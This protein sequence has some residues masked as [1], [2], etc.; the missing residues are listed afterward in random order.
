[1]LRNLFLS[2][3]LLL[4]FLPALKGDVLDD[5]EV[6]LAKVAQVGNYR[7]AVN[8][9]ESRFA[10]EYERSLKHLINL[11]RDLDR[12]SGRAIPGSDFAFQNIARELA[13]IYEFNAEKMRHPE[14]YRKKQKN[15][16]RNSKKK[17]LKNILQD[18]APLFK[19]LLADI[20]NLRKSGFSQEGLPAS[21]SKSVLAGDLLNFRR[22]LT[23]F[24]TFRGQY[25][26]KKTP[27]A[28]R[29]EFDRRL[30]TLSNS[31]RKLQDA[32]Q[33]YG[34]ESASLECNIARETS[35]ILRSFE[36]YRELALKGRRGSGKNTLSTYNREIRYSIRKIEDALSALS[37]SGLETSFS[38]SPAA[39]RKMPGNR[40]HNLSREA[41][42][43]ELLK[44]RLRI[45]RGNVSLDGVDR[46]TLRKYLLTLTKEERA[47]Y[48]KIRKERSAGGYS[49]EAAARAAL[50]NIQSRV[51]IS[52]DKK[53]L[54]SLLNRLEREEAKER[55][56]EL[57]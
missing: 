5:F 24:S 54:L 35:L 1:M 15:N 20:K 8:A 6:E 57:K 32:L 16:R 41:L 17:D 27:E 19:L 48:E 39:V 36:R 22:S 21:H 26:R 23:F 13:A 40:Y 50:L 53:T 31:S 14:N 18:P 10:R 33:R 37:R 51:R 28:F 30:S 34:G 4:L 2:F 3:V 12:R 9:P 52:A 11:G 42:E 56:K 49:G 29:K 45:Y 44:H 25:F 46:D 55:E 38:S 43:K 47:L 7:N